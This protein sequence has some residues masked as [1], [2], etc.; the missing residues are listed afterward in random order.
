MPDKLVRAVDPLGIIAL[1][2]VLAQQGSTQICPSEC[3]CENKPV[4]PNNGC[5]CENKPVQSFLDVVTNPVFREA[6]M[7]LDVKKL[8]SIE[9]FLAIAGEIRHKMDS[10]SVPTRS[11]QPK[12][13]SR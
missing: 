1:A 7:G 9:D 13:K 8:R 2:Q 10:P 5:S 12:K 6:V 11:A 4:C 3:S